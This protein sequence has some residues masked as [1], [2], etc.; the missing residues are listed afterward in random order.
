MWCASELIGAI[1]GIG[2]DLYWYVAS[3]SCRTIVYKGMLMPEQVA[4]YYLDLHD[5]RYG[6]CSGSGA[7]A[8]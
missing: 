6:K 7:F 2:L 5:R 4:Q 3:A 1:R 8:L